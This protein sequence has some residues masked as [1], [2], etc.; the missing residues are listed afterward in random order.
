MQTAMKGKPVKLQAEAVSIFN[1]GLLILRYLRQVMI[2]KSQ[3]HDV[4]S[5]QKVMS[6]VSVVVAVRGWELY[7]Y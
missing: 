6:R 5:K 3:R 1:S 2:T 7:S 4:K